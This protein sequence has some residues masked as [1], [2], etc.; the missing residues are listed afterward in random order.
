MNQKIP[1]FST[2][3]EKNFTF[4]HYLRRQIETI[5]MFILFKQNTREKSL[6]IMILIMG[7]I[8]RQNKRFRVVKYRQIFFSGVFQSYQMIRDNNRYKFNKSLIINKFKVL[9]KIKTEYVYY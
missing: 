9:K 7:I 1:F 6:T 2:M 3:K 4:F 8:L 5:I